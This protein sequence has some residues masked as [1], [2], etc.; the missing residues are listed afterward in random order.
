VLDSELR[1]LLLELNQSG[2]TVLRRMM[3]AEQWERDEAAAA[4][5]R[6]NTAAASKVAE[7]V[8]LASL[9]PDARRQLIRVLGDLE[10]TLA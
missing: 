10:A 4:L 1:G 5:L 2:R 3:L 6:Y 9:N 8:D 7:I